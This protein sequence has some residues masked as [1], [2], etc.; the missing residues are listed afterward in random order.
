M[1]TPRKST[2][3]AR[4]VAK[5]CLAQLER[6][7]GKGFARALTR[8]VVEKVVAGWAFS[9]MQSAAR[10]DL[11]AEALAAWGIEV[12]NAALEILEERGNRESH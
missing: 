3:Q 4:A 10:P 9:I 7:L 8:D 1:N 5:T 2:P 11:S 12:Y 6:Q